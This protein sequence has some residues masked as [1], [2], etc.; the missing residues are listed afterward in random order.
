MK[1]KKRLVDYLRK[2][3]DNRD[4]WLKLPMRIKI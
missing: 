4:N 1:S 2:M 3:I